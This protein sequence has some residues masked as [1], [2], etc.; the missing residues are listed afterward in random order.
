MS[1]ASRATFH[2]SLIQGLFWAL[3]CAL[4]CFSSV[5][6][7]EKGFSNSQI[8]IFISLSSVLSALLQP[9]AAARADR[10]V[11]FTLRQITALLLVV[12]VL[13][14]AA[15]LVLPGKILQA[16]LYMALLILLQIV[17]PF[18]SSLGMDCIN[19]GTPLNFGLA[20]GVGVTSC[21]I[22]SSAM[23]VLVARYGV[24][25]IPLAAVLSAILMAL[26]AQTFR[27]A[28]PLPDTVRERTEEAKTSLLT[29][30]RAYPGLPLLLLGLCMLHTSHNTLNSYPYQI[31]QA[32][33]GTSVESGM[34]VTIQCIVDIPIMVFFARLQKLRPT[35][36]W[37]KVAAVSY[38]LHALAM[39]LSPTIGLLYVSQIFDMTGFGLYAVASVLYV[40]E[41]IAHKDRVQG[42]TCFAVTNT[43]GLIFG[44]L[45][46]GFLLDHGG[47]SIMLLF[48]VVTG[49]V[50]MVILPLAINRISKK[51]TAV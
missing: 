1:R 50:G 38:F 22:A 44:S 34:V 13:G 21:G 49:A 43:I 39:W 25:V 16:G 4:V 36:F 19:H 12:M 23:G 7:L 51:T 29:F 11:R 18:M 5:Y 8:G 37:L 27:K 3:Y 45:I 2:Y 33:G 32:L 46:G 9:V 30:L 15:L 10:M 41:T 17:L 14:G 28:D 6:L 47:T 48:T 24:Q 20:R 26:A 42:Q 35:A 31:V 40:N